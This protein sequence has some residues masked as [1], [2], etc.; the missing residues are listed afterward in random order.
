MGVVIH[1]SHRFDSRSIACLCVE[2]LWLILEKVL[3]IFFHL[4]VRM[5]TRW[6]IKWEKYRRFH[7]DKSDQY[8]G[9]SSTFQRN[10][11][12]IIWFSRE[13]FGR[14]LSWRSD[15]PLFTKTF[16]PIVRTKQRT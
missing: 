14:A 6:S 15:M 1:R 11:L 12:K 9:C 8:G 3:Y 2:R 4:I 13:T 7:G 5:E 10:F 16:A